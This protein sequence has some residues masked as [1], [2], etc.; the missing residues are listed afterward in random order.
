MIR[1]LLR[2]L[3]L[4]QSFP[5]GGVDVILPAEHL[6]PSYAS[7]HGRYDKFLP[8][9]VRR[10]GDG[11][12]VVDVGAN[13]GDT[14]AAMCAARPGAVFL[15]I[16]PEATFFSLLSANASRIA[17]A[18]GVNPPMMRSCMVGMLGVK[19][20]L[21]GEGGTRKS[22]ESGEGAAMRPLDDI[23]EEAGLLQPR[24]IKSDVDGFDYDVL[25]SGSRTIRAARPVLFFECQCDD[26][27]QLEAYRDVLKTLEKM[28]YT[29]WTAFDNYGGVVLC[30]VSRAGM[31]QL[32]DYVWSQRS[33]SATRTM[34]YL[35]ILAGKA[36]DAQLMRDAVRDHLAG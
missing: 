14:Y 13:C 23:L 31:D 35:D 36:E 12:V 10:L 33:A 30:D 3:G 22:V 1:R 4:N 32:L 26:E 24:L 16:E 20:V 28:G 5:I 29:S 34:Y 8:H 19:K 7:K 2:K 11:D 9:L 25:R 6:L 21:T 27:L 17:S 15:C 18:H